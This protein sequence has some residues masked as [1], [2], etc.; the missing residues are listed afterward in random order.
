MTDNSPPRRTDATLVHLRAW[1]S[2]KDF[3]EEAKLPAERVLCE[4]LGVKRGDLRKALA[5][6]EREGVIWRHVGKGT[7]I[8]ARPLD[9]MLSLAQIESETNPAEVMRARLLIEPILAREAARNATR[10]DMV[11]IETLM[12]QARAAATWRQYEAL[13]TALHRTIARAGANSLMLAIF[14]TLNTVR[15]SVV[16]GRLRAE[17]D[18]PPLDHHSFAEHEAVVAAIKTRDVNAAG[19]AMFTHLQTVAIKLDPTMAR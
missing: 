3:A 15:R 10:Q 12:H 1:L 7:F 9:N 13:D 16:W 8:G 5:V 17:P 11:E 19:E 2:Q 14:D 6:L 4:E 18:R